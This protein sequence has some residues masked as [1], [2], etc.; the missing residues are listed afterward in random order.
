MAT[1]INRKRDA[2]PISGRYVQKIVD[3]CNSDPNLALVETRKD[4]RVWVI[5]GSVN[6]KAASNG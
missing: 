6:I 5:L 3:R 4:R 2:Q 1:T